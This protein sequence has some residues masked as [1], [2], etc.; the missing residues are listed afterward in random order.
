MTRPR[1]G[2]AEDEER[3]GRANEP[4]GGAGATVS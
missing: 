4:R 3:P 2:A 1:I